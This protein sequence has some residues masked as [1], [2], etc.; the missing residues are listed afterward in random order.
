MCSGGGASDQYAREQRADEQARK[1]RIVQGMS[2]INT[3]FSKF[4]DAFYG[5]QSNEYLDFA[6]PQI[7]DQY[8]DAGRGLAFALSRQGI[9]QSSEGNRRYGKLSQE[10]S[11]NRQG[12]VDKSR[13]VSMNARRQ[14]EDARSGLVAD[15][16]ATADPA[17][18]AKGAISRAAYLNVAP[19]FSP[20]GQLFA[21][22]L[23]G[24]NTYQ[25]ARQ[26]SQAYNDA[27]NAFGLSN[28]PDGSGRN[29]KG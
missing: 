17:A 22:T 25:A 28:T 1:R 14:I 19:T 13:E 18:A 7:N 9:G 10:Y 2:N 11:L 27:L 6:M 12:A 16:Y 23:D 15:L 29:I 21:N 26:D 4:D 24:L 20:V 3:Q 8:T 5:K